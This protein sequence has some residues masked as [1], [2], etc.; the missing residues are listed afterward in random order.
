MG[1]GPWSPA[2]PKGKAAVGGMAL[3][4]LVSL[5]GAPPLGAICSCSISANVSA[6]SLVLSGTSSGNCVW[7]PRIAFSINGVGLPYSIRG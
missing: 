2:P 6:P 3:A 5:L 7:R 4:L 1:R